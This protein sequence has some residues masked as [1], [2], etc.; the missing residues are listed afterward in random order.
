VLRISKL[1]D[2]GIVLL[3]NFALA[4]TGAT[5]TAREMAESTGLPHPVVSKML[6]TLAG[7]AL[8][9]S[10]RGAKGGYSLARAPEQLSVADILEALE[11]PLA[12]MECSAGPGHCGQE[13]SCTVRAPWQHINRAVRG[14]LEGMTLAELAG[15]REALLPV[16]GAGVAPSPG[17]GAPATA[18]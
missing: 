10:Q 2:Y 14:A 12:L 15:P 8:L 6:K 9:R 1:T 3:A 17:D 5:L 16:S 11:G 13:S 18:K 4:P 7:A